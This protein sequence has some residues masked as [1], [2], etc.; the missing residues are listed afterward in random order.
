MRR[1]CFFLTL[2]LI[3]IFCVSP[4]PTAAY[5]LE[6]PHI[7]DQ[8]VKK[9]GNLATV[10]ALAEV[11]IQN[12]PQE[13]SN[14]S[15][16][17]QIAISVPGMT[18][19]T[20]SGDTRSFVRV[21]SR[22]ETL[23]LADDQVIP[24]KV[25]VFDVY[26]DLLSFRSR[27]MLQS[28]LM[29]MGIDVSVSSL[30]RFGDQLVFV[31][32]AKYPDLS[33]PQIWIDKETFLPARWVD[34]VSQV[35]GTYKTMDAVYGNWQKIEKTWFPMAVDFSKE[36][37]VIRKINVTKVEINTILDPSE[38]DIWQIKST[39]PIVAEHNLFMDQPHPFEEN[40]R[41]METDAVMFDTP[42]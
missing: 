2:F 35:D 13:G 33:V 26:L 23:T 24:S 37:R 12:W 19:I 5:V 11:E 40:V 22:S 21:R 28:H 3:G 18:R 9:I 16:T 10:T 14:T 20:V 27:E 4:P 36:D 15:F 31:V 42:F 25:S 38:F 1:Y 29:N 7:L 34:V 8:M 17:Q 32:G 39:H 41:V 6:G 30:G